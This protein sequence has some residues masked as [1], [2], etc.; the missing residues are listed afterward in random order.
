[1]D[2]QTEENTETQY[3]LTKKFNKFFK[4]DIKKGRCSEDHREQSH[5]NIYF[6]FLSNTMIKEKEEYKEKKYVKKSK[7]IINEMMTHFGDKIFTMKK[8][9]PL[10][11]PT[12]IELRIFRYE[13]PILNMMCRYSHSVE[14]IEWFLEKGADPNVYDDDG[15]TPLMMASDTLKNRR[16]EFSEVDTKR[17]LKILLEKG[18]IPYKKGIGGNLYWSGDFPIILEIGK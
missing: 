5:F 17:V 12:D 2:T 11:E 8:V 13:T 9:Y 15:F 7:G 10:V 1:M 4:R 14:L 18:A 6:S 3:L 16:T